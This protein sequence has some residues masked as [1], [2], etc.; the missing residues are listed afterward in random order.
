[1]RGVGFLFKEA[2]DMTRD[3]LEA[4]ETAPHTIHNIRIPKGAAPC[5]CGAKQCKPCSYRRASRSRRKLERRTYDG[6]HYLS[7][8]LTM[9][10]ATDTL[11]AQIDRLKTAFKKLQ[12]RLAWSIAIAGGVY[13]IEF[14]HHADMFRV[15]MHVMAQGYSPDTAAMAADWLELTG[16]EGM[17]GEVKPINSRDY[18]E[19][20]QRYVTKPAHEALF[21]YPTALA[22]S[23]TLA[24]RKRLRLRDYFGSLRGNDEIT[25]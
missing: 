18:L 14:T 19:N 15:H 5:R 13:C 12:R 7:I 10:E 4:T 1:M 9:R 17:L 22:E 21:T 6:S 16:G 11:E 8:T 23:Q 24:N 2:W 25:A 3:T 20:I